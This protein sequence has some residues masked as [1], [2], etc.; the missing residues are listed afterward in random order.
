V[1]NPSLNKSL[2]DL[3]E[4]RLREGASIEISGMGSFELD[5]SQQVVFRPSD[6]PLIFLSYAQEDRGKI[7][8]LYRQLQK[9]DFQPWMD[10][11]KLMPGQN[12]PRAI[13]QTIEISGFFLGCFSRHSILKRGHFQGEI[14]LGLEVATQFPENDVF[15]IPLRL[16]D[17]ELPRR[18][19]GSM[20]YID[21]FP[22]WNR[23]V[24][25][26]VG[27]LEKYQA[28]RHRRKRL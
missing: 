4:R 22:D 21:L 17:C 1:K 9:A 5:G 23:G 27:A 6:S 26:L 2:L 10:C 28:L 15:F 25:K 24:K 20:H 18:I 3:I 19:A 7:K 14:A 16:D 13:Q 12:W 8:K 11:Q